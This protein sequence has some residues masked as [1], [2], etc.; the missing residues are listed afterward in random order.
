MRVKLLVVNNLASGYGEGSVY[1]F[2]RA[3]TRD[4]DEVV[5]RSTD[6]T[7]DLRTFLYDAEDFDAVAAAVRAGSVIEMDGREFGR[8]VRRCQA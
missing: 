7:T 5:I 3:L 8:A 6:G 1:D 4:G 2:V